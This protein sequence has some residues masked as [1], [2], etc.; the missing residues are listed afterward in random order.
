[1][2]DV[3][4]ILLEFIDYCDISECT[5]I[6]RMLLEFIAYREHC[7][8]SECTN[9]PQIL[10]KLL[11][12]KYSLLEKYKIRTKSDMKKWMIKNHPDRGGDSELFVKVYNEFKAYQKK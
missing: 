4:K 1:M 7:D 5:N 12:K 9:I 10:V 2:N 8:I 6:P 11:Q 3:R